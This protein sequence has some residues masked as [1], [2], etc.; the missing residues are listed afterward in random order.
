MDHVSSV[1]RQKGKSQNGGS[2]KT[3]HTKFSEK[4]TFLTPWYANV[5]LRIRG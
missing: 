4:Q 3:K 5:Q 1:T 2:K